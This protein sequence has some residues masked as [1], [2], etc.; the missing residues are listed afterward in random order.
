MI[1]QI[2]ITMAPDGRYKVTKFS[3][4]GVVSAEELS[5]TDAEAVVALAMAEELEPVENA[6]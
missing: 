2:V 4:S 5:R 3:P 1:I 6:P